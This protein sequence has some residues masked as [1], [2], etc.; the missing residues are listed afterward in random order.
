MLCIHNF[1]QA[2]QQYQDGC[3]P[4]RLL[5]DQAAVMIGICSNPHS[6]VAHAME[7]TEGNTLPFLVSKI[8]TP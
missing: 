3:I 7:I 2:H 6:G 1:N 5:Q 4:F 8:K